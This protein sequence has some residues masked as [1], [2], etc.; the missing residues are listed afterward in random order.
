MSNQ[1]SQCARG[2]PSV[3]GCLPDQLPRDSWLFELLLIK[4]NIPCRRDSSRDRSARVPQAFLLPHRHPCA[5]RDPVQQTSR[6]NAG[7]F[8]W[9]RR[10]PCGSSGPRR[11]QT[12]SAG[13]LPA[14]LCRH[15]GLDPGSSQTNRPAKTGL[16]IL[17]RWERIQTSPPIA[18]ALRP[19][20][21][22]PAYSP[23]SRRCNPHK[24][25]SAP[26]APARH[27]SSNAR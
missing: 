14:S 17:I 6:Q 5:G 21:K 10:S 9:E 4:L 7:L 11:D 13:I 1:Y 18:A 22:Q 20:D 26:T 23:A 16:P 12:G 3:S 8:L 15:P 27:P 2:Q 24:P 19:T 25:H